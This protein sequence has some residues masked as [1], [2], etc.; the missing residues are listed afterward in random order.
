MELRKEID[1][2]L[3]RN[4]RPA[5]YRRI[6][7][8]WRQ[9]Q[10][11]AAAAFIVSRCE[12]LRGQLSFTAF[13]LAILRSFTVEPATMLLRAAAFLSGIDLQVHVG[14][15]NAYPQEIL[16]RDSSLYKFSPDA[17]ILAVQACDV[18]PDLWSGFADLSA[19]AVAAAVQR[20]ASSYRQWAR[21]FREHSS[22]SLI[23]HTL[24]QPSVPALGVLDAQ[25]PLHQ[26]AAFEQV[27]QQLLAIKTDLH[28]VFLLDYDALVARHGRRP[29]H[30]QSKWLTARMPVAA[31][32]LVHLA[33]EWLRFLIPL[34][35][36]TAK[37]LVVDLDNTLWGGVIGE[38]GIHGIKL[39]AEYSGAGYQAL[40]RA[41]LDLSR[42]G[43]LLAICSKNNPEDAMEALEHHP[44]MLLRPQHFAAMRINWNDKAQ[45]LRE[46]AAELNIGIDSLA[47]L[48]DNPA[49]RESV[50]ATLPEVT[51]I[52][53]PKDP[54]DYAAA[55]RDCPV[56]ERLALSQEDQERTAL[57][58]AER[59]SSHAAQTFTST[60]DFFRFLDQEAEV[61][62]VG[63]ATLARVAQLTQ[64]TNQFNLTTRRYTE[65]QI[66][67][68]AAGP[69]TQV[70][71]IRVRDRYG[72]H[73][74]VGVAITRDRGADCEI[75]T[76]LL[77]CRVIGR[78]VETALLAHLAEQARSRGRN[79]L[80]GR[81]LP[82]RKNAPARDFYSQNGF[83]PQPQDGEG[84]LWV[85]D[86]TGAAVP[87]PEWIKMNIVNGG[88]N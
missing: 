15:F 61:A 10:G 9:E 51:V 3:D 52:D 11:Q 59:E 34:S 60:E 71:S 7:E 75:D 58:A 29:W 76:F 53:L 36:R 81:F 64:K 4:A 79:R 48:D 45:N 38:D 35:G 63:P 2:L 18:A 57:Y 30:D 6:G 33:N 42:K 46:I 87:P 24:E 67:E 44:D 25:L 68:L 50:R 82:T 88:K 80:L 20:V 69:G 43:I 1:E 47:F 65:Q 37:A 49:E 22:A 77:S 55:L 86:L 14:D 62:P 31:D 54:I 26:R 78:T 13:R 66:A 27:N 56:F 84:S 28:G 39:S 19:E 73:G 70:T 12:K 32:H 72:D 40:Q 74:L 8:L 23:V 41:M 21:A 83:Q 85:L 16:D 17:V 5:A